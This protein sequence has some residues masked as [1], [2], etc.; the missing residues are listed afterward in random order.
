MTFAAIIISLLA[1]AWLSW[2]DPKRRRVFGL[3]ALRVPLNAWPGWLVFSLP[4]AAL[5]FAGTSAGLVIWMGAVCAFGWMLIA[6][7]PEGWH[8]I[9]GWLNR[10]GDG[11]ESHLQTWL[12]EAKH[13]KGRTT[14][15]NSHDFRS[16]AH[17]SLDSRIARRSRDGG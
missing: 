16:Q 10:M 2:R 3:P 8:A 12:Q 4:G 17:H 7:T 9:A 11:F 1:L 13:K 14:G 15:E 6:V 5:L